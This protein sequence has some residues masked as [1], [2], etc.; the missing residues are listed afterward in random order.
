MQDFFHGYALNGI[1]AKGRVSV[2]ASYRD[3]VEARSK[4]RAVLL[5]PHDS[6]PCLIGFDTAYSSRLNEIIASRGD[7]L[8]AE[9]DNAALKLF[10]L[11]ERFVYDEPGRIVLTALQKE[12]FELDRLAF[13]IAKGETFEVW[14]PYRLIEAKEAE[15]PNIARTVRFCLKQKGEP[16]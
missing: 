9:R 12:L 8:S 2:P 5:A 15:E 11:S 14:N 10:G 16:A 13:F 3:V 6:Q 1:D 4:T 7:A